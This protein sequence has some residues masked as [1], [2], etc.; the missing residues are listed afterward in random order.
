MSMIGTERNHLVSQHCCSGSAS[1]G[2]LGVLYKSHA[3]NDEPFLL[4]GLC[5]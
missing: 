4:K 1:S 5:V 2:N 3:G